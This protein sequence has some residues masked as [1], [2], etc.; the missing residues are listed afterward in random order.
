MPRVVVDVPSHAAWIPGGA[1]PSTTETWAGRRGLMVSAVDTAGPWSR[2]GAPL[3]A[4]NVLLTAVFD[5]ATSRVVLTGTGLEVF[6]LVTIER[7]TD[8]ITWTTVRGAVE[9]DVATGGTVVHYDYEFVDGVT[10][11]YRLITLA[12]FGQTSNIASVTPV[13][14]AA[15]LKSISR[16]FLNIRVSILQPPTFGIGR[17]ARVGIYPIKARTFPIAVNDI[18]LARRWTLTLLTETRAA[19][20]AL[21]FILAPG[22]VLLLQV[23]AGLVDTVPAGYISIGDVTRENHPLRPVRVTWTLPAVEVAPPGASVVPLQASWQTL[24]NQ[25][26]SWSAV[27]A[28]FSSWSDLLANL[29]ADPSEVITD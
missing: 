22:D 9:L 21:T 10:N 20:D 12:P 16:P 13:L 7:S 3:L 23:P 24:I 28:D 25:Y 29:V 6:S 19:A 8:L 15:W 26:A 4:D 2:S 17:L 27:I 11:Y 18:R 5:P 1:G 14:T